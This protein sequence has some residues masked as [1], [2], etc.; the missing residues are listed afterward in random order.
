MLRYRLPDA[1]G[2]PSSAF[3]ICPFGR[4]RALHVR[5]EK[6]EGGDLFNRLISY[7]NHLG[8]MSEDLDFETKRQ[9]GNFPQAYSHLAMINTAI[10]LSAEKPISKFMRP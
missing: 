3:P 8:L 2:V 10:L 5:G 1:C 9:L 6:E 4:I 7:S